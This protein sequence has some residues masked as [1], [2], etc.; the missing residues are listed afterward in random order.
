[1]AQADTR[2]QGTAEVGVGD[3][4][5]DQGMGGGQGFGYGMGKKSVYSKGDIRVGV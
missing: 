5:G 2:S 1:M 4:G 3:Q